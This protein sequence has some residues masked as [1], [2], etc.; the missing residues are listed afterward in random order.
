MQETD[1]IVKEH[2]G[3]QQKETARQM[4]ETDRKMLKGIIFLIF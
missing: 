1:R 2:A 4:K 3:L